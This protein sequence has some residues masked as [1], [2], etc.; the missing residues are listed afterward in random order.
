[1]LGRRKRRVVKIVKKRLPTVFSCPNC[2]AEAIRVTA[3][4]GSNRAIIQCGA[5]ELK[6]EMNFLPSEKKIDIYCKFTDKFHSST[7][8]T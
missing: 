1:M 3:L 6:D 5:C 2:G 8:E 4:K 7:E